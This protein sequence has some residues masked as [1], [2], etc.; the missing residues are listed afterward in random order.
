MVFSKYKRPMR[1][2]DLLYLS[3]PERSDLSN[4]LDDFQ[5]IRILMNSRSWKSII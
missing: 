3:V 5:A 2:I 4:F 1:C